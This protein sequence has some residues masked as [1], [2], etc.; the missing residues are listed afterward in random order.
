MCCIWQKGTPVYVSTTISDSPRS[1]SSPAPE[2]SRG[3]R[4]EK[5]QQD[6]PFGPNNRAEPTSKHLKTSVLKH[7]AALLVHCR[8][9]FDRALQKKRFGEISQSLADKLMSKEGRTSNRKRNEE[10]TVTLSWRNLIHVIP[11][12]QILHHLFWWGFVLGGEHAVIFP[13]SAR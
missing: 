6:R 2:T 1:Q 10:V 7:P 3:W 11:E 8:N 5:K 4:E 13:C 9:W 12:K